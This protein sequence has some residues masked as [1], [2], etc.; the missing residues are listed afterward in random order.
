VKVRQFLRLTDI[1]RR[2]MLVIETIAALKCLDA[3]GILLLFTKLNALSKPN[4]GRNGVGFA[5]IRHV[6]R[7][8][9]ARGRRQVQQRRTTQGYSISHF[10]FAFSMWVR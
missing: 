4:F 1:Q 5:S 2:G 8:G 3:F 9:L 6:R 7:F 10:H